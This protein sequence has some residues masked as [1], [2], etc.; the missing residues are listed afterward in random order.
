MIDHAINDL[1]PSPIAGKWYPGK[2]GELASM[3]DRFVAAAADTPLAG[4]I[5]GLIVPHAGYIYS[6][7]TAAAAFKL[8]RGLTYRRVVVISPM[9]SYYDDPILTSGHEAYWTPLGVV[10]VD[11]GMV[12]AL[13]H[14]LP[15]AAV[16]RDPEHALEIELP[17]MQHLL[18]GPFQLIPLMLRDQTYATA[19]EVGTAL[20]TVLKDEEGT[21][22][23]ASSD[24]SHF[25]TDAQA[26]ALDRIML[27]QIVTFDAEKVIRVEDEGRAFA[28]GRAAI[29]AVMIACKAL[30]ASEAKIVAYATSADAS[31]DLTRVVGYGAAALFHHN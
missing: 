20:A 6:G 25:Y 15:L 17:F 14:H 4:T 10:P 31:G 27:E 29:A 24:L 30:G 7:Q 19:W 26:R 3:I 1:R 2:Q 28:C 23:V 21:L 9:H 22:L 13:E 16:R 18:G 5:N 8:I 11:R 12:E